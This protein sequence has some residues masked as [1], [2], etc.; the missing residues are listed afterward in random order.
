MNPMLR[1]ALERHYLPPALM[2]TYLI[3]RERPLSGPP[4]RFYP[5]NVK[6][7]PLFPRDGYSRLCS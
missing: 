3:T 5:E 2:N 6:G 4:L 7:R 1:E